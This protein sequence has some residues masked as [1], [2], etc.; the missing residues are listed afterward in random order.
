MEIGENGNKK[1]VSFNKNLSG[2]YILPVPIQTGSQ[3]R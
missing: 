2:Q 3:G 1:L